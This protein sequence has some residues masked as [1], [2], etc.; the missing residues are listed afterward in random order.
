MVNAW[1]MLDGFHKWEIPNSWMVKK[2]HALMMLNMIHFLKRRLEI[3]LSFHRL[4]KFPVNWRRRQ[5]G[6]SKAGDLGCF[7][8]AIWGQC[9][10]VLW[11]LKQ[12]GNFGHICTYVC[13]YI[14]IH[15][16]YIHNYTRINYM[17]II[18]I[19]CIRLI[20]SK[21]VCRRFL[22]AQV[23]PFGMFTKVLAKGMGQN[24]AQRDGMFS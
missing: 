10:H 20:L 7:G 19:V 8:K 24:F 14:H 13:T 15:Y 2:T 21:F 9:C 16:T 6:E 18:M 1:L 4:P 17:Y 11:R 3:E 5:S 12:H 23:H 22:R